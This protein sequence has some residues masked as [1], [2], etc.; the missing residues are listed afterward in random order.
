MKKIIAWCIFFNHH[1]LDCNSSIW[2]KIK[3]TAAI[4]KLTSISLN[5]AV[6]TGKTIEAVTTDESLELKKQYRLL[7]AEEKFTDCLVINIKSEITNEIPAACLECKQDLILAGGFEKAANL[8]EE[9][10]AAAKT[11]SDKKKDEDGLTSSQKA[12]IISGCVLATAATGFA[13]I[14]IPGAA[15]AIIAAAQ[16]AAE[17]ARDA[18]NQYVSDFKNLST[19]DKIIHIAHVADKIDTS[20][21]KPLKEAEFVSTEKSA[22]IELKREAREKGSLTER[23]QKKYS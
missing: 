10:K 21:I 4:T 19:P 15:P 17:I 23:V 6:V 12:L 16:T 9:F 1:L 18:T 3:L 20:S 5:I 8:I 2:D 13:I 22:L 14:M 7:K 11:I